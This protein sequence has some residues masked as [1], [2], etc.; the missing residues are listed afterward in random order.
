[1]KKKLLPHGTKKPSGPF[2]TIAPQILWEHD[3][4]KADSTHL[5]IFL[6][7]SL[8]DFLSDFGTHLLLCTWSVRY[9]PRALS[10][11]LHQGYRIFCIWCCSLHYGSLPT[12]RCDVGW[13]SLGDSNGYLYYTVWTLASTVIT[14]MVGWSA[15]PSV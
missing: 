11:I 15:I 4:L 6:S 1:M 13:C 3:W 9:S 7:S 5:I 2:S 8:V 14:I 10:S 12:K